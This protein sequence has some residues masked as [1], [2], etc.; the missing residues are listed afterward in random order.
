MERAY[1][2]FSDINGFW[3]THGTIGLMEATTLHVL[4]VVFIATLIRSAFGFGAALRR[5]FYRI[6]SSPG[7]CRA[8]RGIDIRYDRRHHC[9][10][11]LAEDPRAQHGMAGVSDTFRHPGRARAVD[12]QPSA[13]GQSGAGHSDHGVC[14]V[15]VDRRCA[16][17]LRDA[18]PASLRILRWSAGRG[19]SW[20]ERA[21]ARDLRS[22]ALLVRAAFPCY[23][24]RIFSGRV[25]IP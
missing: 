5:S 10:P 11:G 17:E 9:R 19:A 12:K 1:R 2:R 7:D 16:P 20:Y 22:H 13:G 15:F 4:L 24:A 25:S 8:S 18:F 23:C 14:H 21:A 3:A 6:A